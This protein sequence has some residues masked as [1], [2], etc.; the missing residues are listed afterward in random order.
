MKEKVLMSITA[1]LGLFVILVTL[2]SFF[3]VVLAQSSQQPTTGSS[4]T[5]NGSSPAPSN[6]NSAKLLN[7]LEKIPSLS[8]IVGVSMVDGIK[9]SGINVGDTDLSVTLRRQTT[10]A[11][12]TNANN[13]GGNMSSSSSL[14]VTVIATKLPITNLSAVLSTVAASTDLAMA[15]Q[16]SGNPMDAATGQIGSNAAIQSNA[17]QILSLLKNIQIGTASIVN[18]NWTLPQTVSMGFL[19]LGNR[20]AASAP[21]DFVLV[22]VVPFQGISNMP[23]LPLR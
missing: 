20:I 21:S 13:T 22:V 17:F 3:T 4:S 8:N 6:L 2:T 9:V 18:A 1:S 16:N 12:N 10:T 23:T 19:G 11:A 14:P 7:R 5:S 15:T